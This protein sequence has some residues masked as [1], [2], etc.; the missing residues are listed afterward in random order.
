MPVRVRAPRESWHQR[1]GMRDPT[2]ETQ[3]VEGRAALAELDLRHRGHYAVADD[4]RE[5]G[6]DERLVARRG[7]HGARADVW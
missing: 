6:G 1:T 3:T 5:L 2:P 4:L 7:V